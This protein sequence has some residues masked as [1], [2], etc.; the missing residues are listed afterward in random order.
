MASVIPVVVL[1]CFVGSVPSQAAEGRVY[2]LT[3][4]RISDQRGQNLEI[5]L[6]PVDA[7]GA[8][9]TLRFPAHS[10][11]PHERRLQE[12]V[13]A[14]VPGG[15]RHAWTAARGHVILALPAGEPSMS[16][17]WWDGVR[18]VPQPHLRQ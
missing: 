4:A 6:V 2:R 14:A 11:T 3:M 12:A 8:D 17:E 13:W 5:K 7:K 18:I 15:R 1:A 16:Q 10:L 9:I